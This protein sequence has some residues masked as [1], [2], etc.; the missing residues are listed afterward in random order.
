MNESNTEIIES[1]LRWMTEFVELP[2]SV[3]GDLPV[4]PFAKKARLAN[5]ILFKV[6]RFSALTEFDRDSA[7]IQSIHE[8]YNSDFEI[9]LVINPEKTAISA[10][11]TQALIEKLNNNI[12][13]L[14]LLAFHVHPDEDFNID[15]LHTRRAPYPGFTVQVNST[16]KPASDALEKTEYYKNWTAEQLKC[17]GIPRN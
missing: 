10:P 5:Q 9:M 17:F 6:E 15:G 16:L 12:S 13:E 4:C 8:F 14:G 1:T 2:H 3:F 7:I 11:Q